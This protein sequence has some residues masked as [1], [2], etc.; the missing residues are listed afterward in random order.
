M[1]QPPVGQ[2]RIVHVAPAAHWMAHGPERQVSITQV[3]PAAQ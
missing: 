1:V 3:D 2:L